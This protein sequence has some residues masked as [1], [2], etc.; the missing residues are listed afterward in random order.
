[1]RR[2]PW[3][4]SVTTSTLSQSAYPTACR[5]RVPAPKLLGFP[6]HPRPAIAPSA[7]GI[8][9]LL[10]DPP[11]PRP[12]RSQPPIHHRSRPRES[13]GQRR[14]QSSEAGSRAEL[15]RWDPHRTTV[16]SAVSAERSLPSEARRLVGFCT[17]WGRCR[18]CPA[19]SLGLASNSSQPGPWISVHGPLRIGWLELLA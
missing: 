15:R 7:V 9:A 3:L 5:G 8:D 13:F 6:G 19:A 4:S 1:M 18:R 16:S 17:V 12:A 10:S 2:K 11:R 14:L